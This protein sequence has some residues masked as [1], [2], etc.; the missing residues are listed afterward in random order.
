MFISGKS[1]LLREVR[2]GTGAGADTEAREGCCLHYSLGPQGLFSCLPVALRIRPLPHPPPA[3]RALTIV[4]CPHPSIIDE[5]N[6]Q[7]V[8]LQVNLGGIF[9]IGSPLSQM[10]SSLC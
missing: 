1:L 7:E 2:A 3:G 4:S 10:N 6:A 5:E 9:S 8:H